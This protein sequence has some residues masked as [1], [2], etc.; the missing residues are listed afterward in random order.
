MG[1]QINQFKGWESIL[2]HCQRNNPLLQTVSAL[3]TCILY[4]CIK[5]GFIHTQFHS[6]F[7]NASRDLTL[8]YDVSIFLGHALS[9]KYREI[10]MF[11]VGTY[12][13]KLETLSPTSKTS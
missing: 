8:E 6:N 4:T 13:L 12:E 2:E 9:W 3:L 5:Y 11:H 1:A 10:Q 7:E